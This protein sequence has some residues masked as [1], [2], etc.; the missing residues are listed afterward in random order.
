MSIV[1]SLHVACIVDD[2]FGVEVTGIGAPYGQVA[3]IGREMHLLDE[4]ALQRYMI[5]H[6]DLAQL[7]VV[8]PQYGLSRR[9][10]IVIV[11]PVLCID[12]RGVGRA[13]I[14]DDTIQ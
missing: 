3:G 6:A 8:A 2:A 4:S 5:A 1:Q 12:D 9:T 11:A 13:L 10:R 7:H 14:I